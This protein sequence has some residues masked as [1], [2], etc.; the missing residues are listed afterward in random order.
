MIYGLLILGS[1]LLGS[2]SF[3]LL[4]VR[5]LQGT[6]IRSLGSGNAG[7]TNVLRAAGKGPAALVLLLDVTKGALAVWVARALE[8]PGPV[9]GMCA[10]AAVAGH[11]FP[12]YYGFRGG[13]GVATATGAMA[14]LAPLPAVGALGL[15]VLLV[16]TTR[17]VSL[18][19]IGAIG[20]FPLLL[21]AFGRLGWTPEPEVWLLVSASVL[22]LLI[23]GKHHQNLERILSGQENRLGSAAGREGSR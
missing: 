2:I 17:M 10:V 6:D 14:G 3:S 18:G 8:A 16:A 12:I 19:S 5:W 23:V 7:A 15:F 11:V 22:A 1:Y 20:S 9:V 4:T 13:K 21:L